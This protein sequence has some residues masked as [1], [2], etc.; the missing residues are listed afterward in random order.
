[1]KTGMG[2]EEGHQEVR[3][4]DLGEY[5]EDDPGLSQLVY[6]RKI[7]AGVQSLLGL[8]LKF[9]LQRKTPQPKLSESKE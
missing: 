2:A 8:G 7:P 5:R 9:C 4:D 6:K 3:E 1:M